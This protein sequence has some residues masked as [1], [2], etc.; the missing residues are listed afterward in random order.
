VLGSLD[1]GTR[2]TTTANDLWVLEGIPWYYV[3]PLTGD[4]RGWVSGA[5]LEVQP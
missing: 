1:Y 3:T 4:L 2:V 5:Y